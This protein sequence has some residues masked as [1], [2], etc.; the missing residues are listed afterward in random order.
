M[1]YREDAVV[2]LQRQIGEQPEQTAAPCFLEKRRRIESIDL[3]LLTMAFDFS[4]WT[5]WQPW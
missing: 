3:T 5:V 1:G 2:E 4:R